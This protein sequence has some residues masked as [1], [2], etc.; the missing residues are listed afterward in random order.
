MGCLNYTETASANEQLRELYTRWWGDLRVLLPKSNPDDVTAQGLY[1]PLFLR[2]FDE[3]WRYRLLVIGQQTHGWGGLLG[4]DE[5]RILRE[6]PVTSLMYLYESFKLG[7]HYQK[8]PFWTAAH[9]IFYKLSGERN[10]LG[11][12]WTNLLRIDQKKARPIPVIERKLAKIDYILREE[13]RVLHPQIVLFLTGPN[14]D[15]AI[16]RVFPGITFAPTGDVG[17]RF[18]AKLQHPS[19]P[20]HTYRTYHPAYLRRS[21]LWH[22]LDSIVE[23][24]KDSTTRCA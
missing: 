16:Q 3:Y 8:T 22:L 24:I 20:E 10:Q 5:R 11:F 17:S 6:D 7:Q 19:L 18:L 9:Y 14:Y 23:L 4:K 21:R 1:N 2:I 15:S 13:C 12:M